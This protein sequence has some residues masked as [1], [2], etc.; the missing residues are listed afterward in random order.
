MVRSLDPGAQPVRAFRCPHR[1]P[2]TL[3]QAGSGAWGR[4]FRRASSA[5]CRGRYDG[6]SELSAA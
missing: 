6:A 2:Y 5:S 1:R 4:S 3:P